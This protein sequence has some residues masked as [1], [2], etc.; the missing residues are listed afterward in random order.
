MQ[1]DSYSILDDNKIDPFLDNSYLISNQNLNNDNLCFQDYT[2][3]NTDNEKNVILE[4]DFKNL[5]VEN[6]LIENENCGFNMENFKENLFEDNT[7]NLSKI[8]YLENAKF[9]TYK[10]FLPVTN[11]SSINSVVLMLNNSTLTLVNLQGN[12]IAFY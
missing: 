6:Y 10:D 3:V 11:N 2:A 5:A 1:E 9:E 12:L 8:P 7:N 4:Q